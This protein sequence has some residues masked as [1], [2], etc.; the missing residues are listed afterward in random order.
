MTSW[1]TQQGPWPAPAAPGPFCATVEV[2]GS[3][4]ETNRALLLAAL[5]EGPSTITGALEA[6]DTL[7][8]RAALEQ[9]GIRV[10]GEGT[11]LR[12]TPPARLNTPAEPVECGLAGTVMRF[13]PPLALLAGG[14][15]R[16]VGDPAASERPLAPVLQA[17]VQLGCTVSDEVL[18][19]TLQAP[20][21]PGGPQVAIDASAS[22]QFVS[23]LLLSAARL[24]H[25]LELRHT[26]DGEVPS[27]P[28]IEMTLQMLT[29]RGVQA[30]ET[31]HNTWRVEPGP[32][33]ALDQRIEPDLTSSSVFLA[34]AALSGG[35]VTVP[36]WPAVT[37]Q[38]G[39]TIR[40]VLQRMAA[41]V[42]LADGALTVTGTGELRGIDVDLHA[43]SELTPVVAALALF[44]TG[45][46]T[47]RGVAHIRGHETDRLAALETELARVGGQ[48]R[49][50]EDGLR[51]TGAGLAAEGLR[52]AAMLSYADH[53]M[54][55]AEALVGLLVSGCT[56]DDVGCTSKTINHFDEMWG[57]M[58]TSQKPL[59]SQKFGGER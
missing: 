46:S 12:I 21:T 35:S 30:R 59:T 36:G 56:V 23:G 34:A 20:T 31:R 13:L 50:T 8:M 33:A 39:D 43:A 3:K 29:S 27:R 42:E 26:G 4:S 41:R 55:H 7:L 40:E 48:V 17:L 49:Q 37:S 53:R 6:R 25:G 32:I 14:T 57:A 18:P 2:P 38:G 58:L 45:D 47:I 16:F 9:F 11:T 44:A 19:F 22:S 24:P 10:Q 1:T 54:V 51:I 5:A 15:T 52:P 28:H